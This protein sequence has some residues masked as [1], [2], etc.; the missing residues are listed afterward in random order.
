MQS[1]LDITP[2]AVERPL[3]DLGDATARDRKSRRSYS[4]ADD[5]QGSFQAA[6]TVIES[7]KTGERSTWKPAVSTLKLVQRQV[8]MKL[9]GWSLKE[10]ELSAAILRWVFLSSGYCGTNCPIGGR[11]K[12]NIRELRPG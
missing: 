1:Q 2:V 3:L 9:C 7:R 11:R 6:L 12:A 8:A 10:D 4:Q 5:Y